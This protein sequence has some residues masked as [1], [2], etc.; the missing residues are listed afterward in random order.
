MLETQKEKDVAI[1]S[2]NH[3]ILLLTIQKSAFDFQ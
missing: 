2:H 3:K 1:S